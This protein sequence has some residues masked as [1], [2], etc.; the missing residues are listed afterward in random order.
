MA[1]KI[2]A[3]LICAPLLLSAQVQV[4][5]AGVGGHNTAQGVKRIGALLRQYKPAVLVIG[6]GAN[7]AVNSR[8]L[9]PEK[10]FRANLEKMITLARKSGVRVIVLNTCNPCVDSYLA[11]RHKYPDGLPPSR[12]IK[13]YNGFTA[14]VAARTGVVLNDFHAAVTGRGGASGEGSS[15]IRNVAN[16]GTKDGLHITA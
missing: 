5:N 8:A 6:Y 11:A 2:A 9:I 15:L 13:M 10:D 1:K 16:T 14:D 3:W 7:D 12:R 4:F